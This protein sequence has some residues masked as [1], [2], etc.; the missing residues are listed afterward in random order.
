MEQTKK[1]KYNYEEMDVRIALEEALLENV[2]IHP[3]VVR[4]TS[5]LYQTG[6]RQGEY[7]LEDYYALPD[8]CRVELI[9]GVIYDMASPKSVHQLIGGKIYNTFLN[10]IDKKSG[11]C[12]PFYAPMDVQLDCDDKTILQPDVLIVCDREKIRNKVV[13]GAPDLV[14]E[15]LS[16]STRRKDLTIKLAKYSNAD[17]REYWIIDPDKKKVIVYEFEKNAEAAMYGFEHKVSAGIFDGECQVDFGE[18]EKYI[19]FLNV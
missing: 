12:I 1:N 6:K 8:D 16:R 2:E 9:D 7:T 10:F 5:A 18:I 13:Y 17:V 3:C 14:V 15:V 4:E 19:S 11:N